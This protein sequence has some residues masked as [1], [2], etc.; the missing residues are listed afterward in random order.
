MCCYTWI[1]KFAQNVLS[2]IMFAFD[3]KKISL[4]IVIWCNEW[5]FVSWNLWVIVFCPVL[6]QKLQLIILIIASLNRTYPIHIMKCMV[7]LHTDAWTVSKYGV[8]SG[9]YFPVFGQ[10]TEIYKVFEHFSHSIHWCNN[11]EKMSM[12][13]IQCYISYNWYWSEYISS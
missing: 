7:N 5:S 10:N 12:V 3:K 8:F 4:K 13:A 11:W 9:A 2:S 6:L 1:I